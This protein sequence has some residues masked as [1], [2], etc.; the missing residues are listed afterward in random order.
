M[1]SMHNHSSPSLQNPVSNL[2]MDWKEKNQATSSLENHVQSYNSS[3]NT[4]F[5]QI[6][7]KPKQE[8]VENNFYR[9]HH[10]KS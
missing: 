10:Q 3:S 9:K 8:R 2:F 5:Q 6:F 7:Q 1:S 4:V